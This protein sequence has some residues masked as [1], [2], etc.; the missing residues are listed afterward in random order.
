MQP[1]KAVHLAEAS[2]AWTH[3]D[4][5]DNLCA[6]PSP[7]PNKSLI[8]TLPPTHTHTCASYPLSLSC[9]HKPCTKH[10]SVFSVGTLSPLSHLQVSVK[11]ATDAAAPELTTPRPGTGTADKDPVWERGMRREGE[12]VRGIIFKWVSEEVSQ[13]LGCPAHRD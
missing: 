12:K 13:L 8:P 3:T 1:T 2:K 7:H 6:S 4:W 10:Q 11:A 9:H 5:S